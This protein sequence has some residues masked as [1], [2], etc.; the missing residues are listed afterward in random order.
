[1]IYVLSSYN[2]NFA[3]TVYI[4]YDAIRIHYLFTV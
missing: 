2:F 4:Q 1:M 3:K